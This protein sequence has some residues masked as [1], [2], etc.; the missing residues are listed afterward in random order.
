M[1]QKTLGIYYIAT[2]VYINGF[3]S[4]IENIYN[5]FPDYKKTII[6]LSDSLKHYN[7]KHINGIKI[8]VKNITHFPWPTI[9]LFKHFLIKENLENFDY[10]CYCNADLHYND[11]FNLYDKLD[12]NKLIVSKHYK[13]DNNFDALPLNEDNPN[14]KSY[15]GNN[16]YTY[17]NGGFFIGPNLI[18]KKLCEDITNWVTLDL[19]LGIIPRWHDE[20]YL[21]KWC[22]INQ[23][24]IQNNIRLLSE[25]DT[26]DNTKMFLLNNFLI[27]KPKYFNENSSKIF[28]YINND[29]F[30]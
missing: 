20:T 27:K 10:I 3:E 21:N 1:K 28:D 11:D 15:I 12:M 6:V 17:V 5:F 7:N 9:T 24:L 30:K 8:K 26:L 19:M 18:V 16:K 22:F 25:Y 29:F 4:F 2:N 23:N 13:L 14:S